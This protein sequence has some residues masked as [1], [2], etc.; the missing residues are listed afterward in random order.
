MELI[1]TT[2]DYL[3]SNPYMAVGVFCILLFFIIRLMLYLM[4]FSLITGFEKGIKIIDGKID[5]GQSLTID[6]TA[7]GNPIVKLSQNQK[8]GSE[9]TYSFWLKINPEKIGTDDYDI[10]ACVGYCD[11]TA[12]GKWPDEDERSSCGNGEKI[13]H[14][15]SKGDYI[16]EI[17]GKSSTTW[18]DCL[19]PGVVDLA[20]STDTEVYQRNLAIAAGK[21]AYNEAS[22]VDTWNY[23]TNNTTWALTPDHFTLYRSMLLYVHFPATAGVLLDVGSD[24]TILGYLPWDSTMGPD[25]A[26][27]AIIGQNIIDAEEGGDVDDAALARCEEVL[28]ERLYEPVLAAWTSVSCEVLAPYGTGEREEVND[29]REQY[30]SLISDESKGIGNTKGGQLFSNGIL[31]ENNGPGV[32]LANISPDASANTEIALIIFMDTTQHPGYNL[33]PII[34]KKMP[35]QKWV[36]VIITVKSNYMY[37]Y[38]NGSL[39]KTNQYI[40]GSGNQMQFKQNYDNIEINKNKIK[41]GILADLV[42]YPRSVNG[43]EISKIVQSKPNTSNSKIKG[44]EIAEEFPNYLSSSF[45]D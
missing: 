13:A 5:E 1:N 14:V 36:N 28:E 3:T 2:Y 30:L 41:W 27:Y 4:N 44:S 34:I 18:A 11:Y 35:I 38:I 29:E 22:A 26:S 6:Q 9:F 42:Y 17:K 20:I 37:V 39:K 8:H 33:E 21:A 45:Y 16:S 31:K 24:D 12:A 7:D 25:D 15:F 43:Y 40:D 32:Y 23:D 19:I 10:S